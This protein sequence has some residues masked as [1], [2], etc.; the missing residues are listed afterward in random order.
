MWNQ[1]CSRPF[2]TS[3]EKMSSI[4]TSC[5]IRYCREFVCVC[6]IFMCD[7]P[8]TFGMLSHAVGCICSSVSY[9]CDGGSGF[10]QNIDTATTWCRTPADHNLNTWCCESIRSHRAN[11]LRCLNL[12]DVL[13]ELMIMFLWTNILSAFIVWTLH[14]CCY[15]GE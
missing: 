5:P 9:W 3:H 8:V 15:W 14:H 13:S 2:H 11:G 1:Y 6:L 12:T 10:L 7:Q 4:P